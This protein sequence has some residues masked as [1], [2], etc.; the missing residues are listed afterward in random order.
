MRGII[1]KMP[2]AQRNEIIEYYSSVKSMQ[3]TADKYGI[4]M[5]TLYKAF[6]KLGVDTK[7]DKEKH[8]QSLRKRTYKFDYFED[9]NSPNKAYILGWILSDGHFYISPKGGKQVRLKITD[10]EVLEQMRI[11]LDYSGE[12]LNGNKYKN[13]HKDQKHLILCGDK[14]YDDLFKVGGCR[15]KS[16]DLKFP[17]LPKDYI[18]DFMRGFFDGDGCI[19]VFNQKN[20]VYGAISIIATEEFCKVAQELCKEFGITSHL[21]YDRRYKEGIINIRIRDIA[22][23]KKFYE[24]I[25]KT[26]PQSLFLTRKKDKFHDFFKR[27]KDYENS[28]QLAKRLI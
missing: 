12:L 17:I 26:T 22:S 13:T 16:F 6:R 24:L 1:G 10:L 23:I 20:S 8:K 5:T 21:Q 3:K 27:R 7:L 25:Y 11:E 19:Y 18:W 28:N 4:K 9:I 15:N 2:E 14:I